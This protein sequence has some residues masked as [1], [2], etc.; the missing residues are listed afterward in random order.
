M[1][2]WS[3]G[4]VALTLV[5]VAWLAPAQD[6]VPGAKQDKP[7]AEKRAAL[8]SA[9]DKVING[10][11]YKHSHWGLLVADLES[12][13]VLYEQNADKLFPPASVTKLFTV[14]TA[15]DALGAD[16]CFETPV[17]R[18]GEVD[19]DGV[20]N[21]DLVLIASGD[22]ALGGRTLP[23]GTLAFTSS[24]HTYANTFDGSRLTPTDPLA[25]LSELARQ[26][27][28]AGIKRVKGEVLIDDRL[29]EHAVGTGSGPVNLTPVV[30]NDNVIDLTIVPSKDEGKLATVLSRPLNSYYQLDGQVRTV[31]ANKDADIQVTSPR[32]GRLVVR[33]VVPAG[34][35]IL[36]IHEVEDP[37]SFA[38][39]LFIDA[40]RQEGVEVD[41]S[42]LT[43]N[44]VSSLKETVAYRLMP[45]VALL[46]SPPF[47]EFV[48]FIFKT[49]H[50]LAAGTLPLL[51]AAK[52]NQRTLAD[53]F[54][55]QRQFLQR[56]GVD[57]KSLSFGS[58]A[59]LDSA[60]FTT[61]RATVQLLRHMRTRPDFA[62]YRDALP[63]VG[64]DG[65]QGG[66]LPPGS[67]AR[68]KV[69]AKDGTSFIH[70]PLQDQDLLL[71]KGLAGYVTTK[72]ERKVVFAIFVSLAH[73]T[74]EHHTERED[75][76]LAKLAELIYTNE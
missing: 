15:L 32:T 59:G 25:G 47:K 26:V 54:K 5:F 41:A 45:R 1:R 71:C 76:V 50:N 11:D 24:D 4:L 66:S 16:H 61:P 27:K 37:A 64:I 3:L 34:E 35:S 49:S 56:A 7:T 51:V 68:G 29:F 53:G 19:G 67:P 62:V 48:R 20:L 60:D 65:T 72:S 6:K 36:R 10:P 44:P 23:D 30:V 43:D 22:L 46:K 58:G 8:K 28:A 57:V 40:L 73:L 52:K 70:N 42:P 63:D 18:D 14:A 21:G 38:R 31:A 9:I 55:E 75:T 69:R 74:K 2:G 12:G 17:H 33:G 13:E 39:S